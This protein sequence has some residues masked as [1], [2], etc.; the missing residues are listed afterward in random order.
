MEGANK[1]LLNIYNLKPQGEY[2]LSKSV[3]SGNGFSFSC[4]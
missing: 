3:N 4:F 2:K 1:S